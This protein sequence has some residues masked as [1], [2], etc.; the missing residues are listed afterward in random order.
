MVNKGDAALETSGGLERSI[1]GGGPAAMLPFV[2]GVRGGGEFFFLFCPF[3]NHYLRNEPKKFFKNL[4]LL[5]RVNLTD[6]TRSA[7]A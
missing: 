6:V 1:E 7:D 2:R 4:S 3:L 5:S